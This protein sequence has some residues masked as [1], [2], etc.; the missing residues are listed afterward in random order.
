[1]TSP[2]RLIERGERAP[3]F[4]LPREGEGATRFYGLVG[5]APVVLL[6]SGSRDRR[7][8]DPVDRA[9]LDDLAAPL[10]E[11]VAAGVD[12]HVVDRA[13]TADDGAFA[14]ADG[15]VH[16]AYGVGDG[17]GPAAVV[18]DHNVRVT[19]AWAL[20]D[21]ED[22]VP[23]ITAALP[24]PPVDVGRAPRLAPVLF[25]PDALDPGM[26]A[27]LME[28]WAD[29]GATETGVETVVEGARAEAT[30]VRRKRR[31]DLTVT[32]QAQL[33]E[34]TQHIGRRVIPEVGKAFAFEAGGFEGFK[35]GCYEADAGGFFAPHRDNLSAATAH[36]RFGLTLNLNDGYEGGELRFP[37]YGATRYRPAAGEALVFS[38]SHLHE[39]LPV[40]SGRRF[41]LLSFLLARRGSSA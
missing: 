7:A 17:T 38:G 6:F 33:R 41:V 10:A 25:V 23:V 8:P 29:G 40:T 21:L 34:L 31:R 16:G 35:I 19:G 39:V 9:A 18:L 30:D 36:R 24:A 15:Q 5:G 3:D 1:M 2:A 14:D 11:A 37:E 22:P 4:A 13:G 28:L 26:C 27:W 20:D 12:V 32:D